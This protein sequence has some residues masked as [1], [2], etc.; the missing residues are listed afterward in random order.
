MSTRDWL[1]F[2]LLGLIWGSSFLW[3]KIGL[4]EVDPMTL[5][6]YRAASAA[7]GLAIFLLLK[8]KLHL[9]WSHVLPFLFLGVVNAA[10]P[11]A[12]I[13]WAELS[14]TSGMASILNSTSPLWIIL[15][16]PLF[17][18]DERVTW[19][20]VVG[21]L[22]GFA[23]VV[24]LMLRSLSG[25]VSPLPGVAAMLIAT[26]CYAFGAIFIRK[27]KAEASTE[28]RVFGQFFMAALVIFPAAAVFEAPF[29]IPALPLTWTA[30]LWLGLLGSA[31]ASILYFD[32]IKSAGPTRALLVTYIFPLV[33]VIL[34]A[35]FLQEKISINLVIGGLMIL[36][37]IWI[38][39]QGLPFGRAKKEQV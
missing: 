22:L 23:G 27:N 31:L 26:L 18:A 34:G 7:A 4:R 33:G 19:A 21:L 11:F 24:V 14:I 13:T 37:G 35:I 25:A 16:G 28:M 9:K 17:L 2:I 12:L 6:T 8:K 29:A 36:A 5:V 20:R 1:K 32:L 39:N 38:V 3:I 15:L 30:L 10:A